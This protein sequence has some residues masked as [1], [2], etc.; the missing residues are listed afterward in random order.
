M[1]QMA[2]TTKIAGSEYQ[3]QGYLTVGQNF[4]HNFEVSHICNQVP[5]WFPVLV[6]PI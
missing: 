4:Q 1:A 5:Q 2:Q 3:D 6:I